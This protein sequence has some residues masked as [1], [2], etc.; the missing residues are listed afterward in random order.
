MPD[1]EP[2]DLAR[3]ERHIQLTG[4]FAAII[5]AGM[6]VAVYHLWPPLPAGAGLE[7]R[8]GFALAWC[9]VPLVYVV[10]AIAWVA[11]IRRRSAADVKGSAAGPPSPRLALSRAFLQNTL[12]QAFITIGAYLVLAVWSQGPLLGLVAPAA[13]LFAVGRILFVV[14]YRAA[15]VGRAFG[16][17]L[18]MG[19]TLVL[20]GACLWLV[21]GAL[22]IFT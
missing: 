13:I 18:T 7:E 20:Y 5:T 17:H 3:T 10:G 1:A 14:L 16:M 6:F 15:P 9:L 4:T 8:L 11:G 12:E 21:A 19:P 2:V 22:P